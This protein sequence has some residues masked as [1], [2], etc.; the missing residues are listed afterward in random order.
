M[1]A[2]SKNNYADIIRLID[3]YTSEGIHGCTTCKQ[4]I[5]VQIRIE[6]D[7]IV[8]AGGAA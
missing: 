5:R 7:T 6:G 3:N 8:D 1:S 2:K 4:N